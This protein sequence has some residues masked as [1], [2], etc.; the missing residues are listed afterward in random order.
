M[1]QITDVVV[2]PTLKL[3]GAF[4]RRT[5]LNRTNLRG[6][7]L[8]KADASGASFRGADFADAQL[9]GT[10]LNGADLTDAVNLTEMQLARA[11]LDDATQLPDYI[12]RSR[13]KR[14]KT[15]ARD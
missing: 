5:N 11:V 7:N 6:A 3:N 8:S 2:A 9:D 1:P 12:D 14:L 10:I 13:L 4:I 15:I